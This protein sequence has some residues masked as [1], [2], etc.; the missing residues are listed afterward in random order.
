MGKEIISDSY[1]CFRICTA[2]IFVK[3]FY[4]Q[5]FY[6]DLCGC[7][8][9][10][11]LSPSF[12]NMVRVSHDLYVWVRGVESGRPEEF[13]LQSP[14]DPYVNLSIHTAPASLTLGTL[15]SQ[16]DAGSRTAPPSLLVGR[17]RLQAGSS[18][19]LQPHYRTFITTA[20]RFAPVRCIDTFPLR[21]PH[22]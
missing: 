14:L 22:L 21:G 8:V 9:N 18:P 16:A 19:S 15:R 1:N 7:Y 2:I 10:Q 12:S 20:G 4:L 5:F 3:L 13:H 11:V 6:L 17:H